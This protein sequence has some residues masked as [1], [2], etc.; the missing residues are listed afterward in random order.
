MA[1]RFEEW[2]VARQGQDGDEQRRLGQGA[3]GDGPART[4][5]PER[6]PG[7]QAGQ[8][9]QRRSHQQE[10]DDDEE[11]RRRSRAPAAR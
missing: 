8:R 11:V 3:D 7:V 9:Q 6:R 5:A 1:G 10:V 2:A 4:H